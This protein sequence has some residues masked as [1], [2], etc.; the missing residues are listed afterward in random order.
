[1]SLDGGVFFCKGLTHS[2]QF[3]FRKSGRE[4]IGVGLDKS[5]LQW[6]AEAPDDYVGQEENPSHFP[7]RTPIA[8]ARQM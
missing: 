5:R 2:L 7:W 1:M 6:R 8:H 3:K 4:A